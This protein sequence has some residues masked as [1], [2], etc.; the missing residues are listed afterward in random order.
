MIVTMRMSTHRICPRRTRFSS[1]PW[2]KRKKRAAV[3]S[4]GVELPSSIPT[5]T[6]NALV[7]QLRRR[8]GVCGSLELEGGR[9]GVCLGCGEERVVLFTRVSAL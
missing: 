4:R 9:V 7:R 3:A 6:A 2:A 8:A 1:A 5:G